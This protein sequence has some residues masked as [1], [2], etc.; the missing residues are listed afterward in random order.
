MNPTFSNLLLAAAEPAP[1]PG[2]GHRG[3]AI[4]LLFIIV[5]ILIR[6]YFRHRRLQMW[7]ETARLVL[8]KG[9]PLPDSL[10]QGFGRNVARMGAWR[11][12]RIGLLL[13]AVGAGLYL[14]DTGRVAA[15]ILFCVGGAH[16]LLGGIAFLRGE[17]PGNFREPPTKP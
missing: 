15:I 1:N 17:K 4:L 12:L 16:F 8:E 5:V 2:L 13:A 11:D 3:L 9:Q 7:H 10:L 14:A 6:G